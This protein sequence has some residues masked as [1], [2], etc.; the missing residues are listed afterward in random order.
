MTALVLLA[1]TALLGGASGAELMAFGDSW[2]TTGAAELTKLGERENFTVDNQAIPGTTAAFWARRPDALKE[3]VDDAPDTRV[4]WF[5]LG[6][7]DYITK[8]QT[9]T[10]MPV[11]TI[12]ESAYNDS[13]AVLDPLFKAYPDIVV[14]G[15]GYEIF[16]WEDGACSTIAEGLFFPDCEDAD[17]GLDKTCANELW[18]GLHGLHGMLAD[19]YPENYKRAEIIGALQAASGVPGAGI[20][21]PV[22]SEFSDPKYFTGGGCIHANDLGYEVIFS[23]LYDTVLNEYLPGILMRSILRMRTG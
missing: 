3:K 9:N 17:G 15:F 6:G 21:Q 11:E 8:R 12:I 2:G 16:A 18:L 5:T 22:I 19:R 1:A 14:V 20:G 7:N 4:I 10:P 23:A 13:Q